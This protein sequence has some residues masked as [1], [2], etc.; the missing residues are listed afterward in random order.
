[1]FLYDF[2]HIIKST[3]LKFANKHLFL[4]PLQNCQA[5]VISRILE[6]H[7]HGQTPDMD[8]RQ[9]V[10]AVRVEQHLQNMKSRIWQGEFVKKKKK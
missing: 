4:L 2:I 9:E 7:N 8:D 6:V 3:F 5:F 1:M 10:K